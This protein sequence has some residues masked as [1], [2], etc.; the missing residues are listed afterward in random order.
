M[1]EDIKVG[2]LVKVYD[3]A[4]YSYHGLPAGACALV[5]EKW[6]KQRYRKDLVVLYRG[7]RKFV[8]STFCDKVSE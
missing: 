3:Y 4:V 2:D 7:E 1:T 6:D 8:S 5:V